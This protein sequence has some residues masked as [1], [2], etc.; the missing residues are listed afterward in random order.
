[1]VQVESRR[2]SLELAVGSYLF[3]SQ[4]ISLPGG[5]MA[6]ICPAECER[7]RA[8]REVLEELRADEANP[9]GEIHFARVRQSMKNGGG[10]ACL[11]LRVVLTE[12]EREQCNPGVFWTR[13]LDERLTG[14][15]ERHYR[16]RLSPEDLRDPMVLEESRSAL[17][18]LTR[19]LDVGC[20]Y[21]FQQ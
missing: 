9:I 15:V 14:W 18:E 3:N 21:E 10:P 8:V 11:R 19:I 7:E 16:D 4:L 5:A 13:A 6:L 1:M 20:L 2:V 17:D 12:R